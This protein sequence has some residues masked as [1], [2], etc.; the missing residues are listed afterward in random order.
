MTI[1]V[2]VSNHH[3]HLTKESVSI[4]FGEGYELTKKRDLVQLG[5]FVCNETVALEKNGKTLENIKII[6]PC[7]TYNQVEFLDSDNEYFNTKAPVRSSGDL[8]NSESITIIGPKGKIDLKDGVIVSNTHI[9][10]SKED[11]L[12][13]NKNNKDI[14]KVKFDNGVVL[15]NVVIKSDDTC[16]LELHINKDIANK[17]NIETGMG[18]NIC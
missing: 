1:L 14:V 11:L 4:L 3:V 17:L 7:R 12:S 18:A 16:K 2:G 13:F 6:G 15:D 5:Q 10:M 9:H 8:D